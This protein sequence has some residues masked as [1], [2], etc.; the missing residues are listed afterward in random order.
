[1][2]ILIVD[3]HPEITIGI[4]HRVMSVLPNCNCIVSN[5]YQ[6]AVYQSRSIQINLLLGDLEFKNDS[7]KDGW[8][9]LDQLKSSNPN[10]KSIA[11][12][13]HS[14]YQIMKRCIDS[15]FNSFLEKGCSLSEFEE[16]LLGVLDNGDYSS[17]SMLRLKRKR[18]LFVTSKFNDSINSIANL[19]R[20]ELEVCILLGTSN[21]VKDLPQ[22]LVSY[23]NKSVSAPSVETYIKRVKEKLEIKKRADLILFCHELIDELKKFN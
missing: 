3:D 1:M 5:S 21:E 12:T 10:L 18:H 16:T 6:D 2:N 17:S 9:L 19:S 23:N 22:L 11:Y 15:G 14:S 13:A 4:K 20:R 8:Q 7:K